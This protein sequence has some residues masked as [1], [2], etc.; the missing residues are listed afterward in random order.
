MTTTTRANI[1][2]DPNIIS[3]ICGQENSIQRIKQAG[4]TYN[5]PDFF[6]I[7]SLQDSVTT[8]IN[9]LTQLKS[10]I[11]SRCLHLSTYQSYSL[12]NEPYLL[13]VTTWG[14]F[15]AFLSKTISEVEILAGPINI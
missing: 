1:P 9:L 13:N 10:L 3:I 15:L 5:I 4:Y 7:S 6:N 14:G 11:I 8:R 2:T 12:T